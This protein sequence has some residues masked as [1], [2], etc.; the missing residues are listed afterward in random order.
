MEF[1]GIQASV[2]SCPESLKATLLVRDTDW[3]PDADSV[4]LFL[5]ADVC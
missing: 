2:G 1:G 4:A 3:V 5:S